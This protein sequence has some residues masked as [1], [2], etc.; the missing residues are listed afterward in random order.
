MS[1]FEI[2]RFIGYAAA[3]RSLLLLHVLLRLFVVVVV[4]IISETSL[5][6]E[7]GKEKVLLITYF[8]KP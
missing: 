5:I 7:L 1:F 2:A 8:M 3:A 6:S 4:V